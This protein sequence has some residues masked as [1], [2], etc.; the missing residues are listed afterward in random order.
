MEEKRSEV[1]VTAA[2]L[3]ALIGKY[4]NID[5]AGMAILNK[6]ADTA[7]S[8]SAH[9]MEVNGWMLV[10]VGVVY[11]LYRT[12]YKSYLLKKLQ[13]GSNGNQVTNG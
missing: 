3:A 13:G 12:G 6:W 5:A 8:L 10:V 1:K 9:P 4:L 2:V 11:G 7:E